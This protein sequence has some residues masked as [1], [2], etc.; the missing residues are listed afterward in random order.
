MSSPL[1]GIEVAAPTSPEYDA[2]LSPAALGFIAALHRT[3]NTRRL[4]LLAQRH[5]TEAHLQAGW[6]PDFDRATAHI[7]ADTDWQ[8]APAPPDMQKRWVE[9][10]GPTDRKMVI[11]ALNSGATH[12][13]AD[14]EDSNVPIWDNL[15]QGQINLYDAIRRQVDFTSAEGKAY[16]LSDT[17]AVLMVR[18]RGWHLDEAHVLVDGEIT[19][20]ALFDFGLY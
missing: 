8:V 7:R 1:A 5:A 2:I 17:P 18:P 14:F 3:F 4:A 19:S 9:I 16:T 11:N 10:T 13:M 6:Q 12:F 15:V 20:G